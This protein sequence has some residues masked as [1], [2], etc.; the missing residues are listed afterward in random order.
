MLYF[1]KLAFKG[2]LWLFL[3]APSF[4]LP[5]EFTQGTFLRDAEIEEIL[6]EFAEPILRTAGIPPKQARLYLVASNELNAFATLGNMIFFNTGMILFT[7]KAEDLVAVMA[8]EIGHL[9]GQHV[10][11]TLEVLERAQQRGMAAAALGALVGGLAGRPDAA[12]AGVMAGLH[13]GERSFLSYSRGQESAA[14]QAG[15]RFL[16]QLGWP[17]E[18][19]RTVFEKFKE[20]DDLSEARQYPYTRTH[21]LSKDR[22]EAIEHSLALAKHTAMPPKLV[23]KFTWL[24]KKIA[25]YMMR[26]EAVL[27]APPTM[28]PEDR[29]ARAIALYRASRFGE[30]LEESQRLLVE[31]KPGKLL[32]NPKPYIHEL[33]AQIFLESRQIPKAITEVEHALREKPRAVL[34]QLLAAQIFIE[35]QQEALRKR[36]IQLLEKLSPEDKEEPFVWRLLSVAYGQAKQMGMMSLALAEMGLRKGDK[37]YA[38][39]QAQRAQQ[40]LPKGTPAFQRASDILVETKQD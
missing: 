40:T 25:A 34:L 16:K 13:L 35:S 39:Q 27:Q 32:H 4:S 24:K 6:K 7:Q 9:A 18:G 20:K 10:V 3:C 33:R 30:A 23:N 19:F 11:R 36:G 37:T 14:D 15:L 5:L 8:H 28:A 29:Y 1:K 2:A 26:P 22:I 12:M 38:A 31:L 17:L 21:P